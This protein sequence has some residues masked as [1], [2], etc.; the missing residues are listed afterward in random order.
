MRSIRVWVLATA[1]TV[2]AGGGGLVVAHLSSD[3][4]A[5]AWAA[6]DSPPA[7]A[8]VPPS[9]AA[10]P[11]SAGP[12]AAQLTAADAQLAADRA[13]SVKQ[14]NAALKS[15]KG[16]FSVAVHDR[17]AGLRYVHRG[18][19]KF[20]TASIVKVQVLTCMLLKAQDAGRGPTSAEMKLARPMI[21]LSDNNATTSL[22][23]RIGGRT[24]V[25]KC[26]K[27][28]GLTQTVVN[29][30]WGLTRTTAADQIRLLEELVD[31]RGPLNASSR[32]TAFTLMNTVDKAQ[33]WGVPVVAR[34]GEIF[35]VKNGWDTRTADGGLWAV[36]TIGRITSKNGKV[37]V[38][39]VVL[40]RRNK[41]YRSGIA[42]VERIAGLTRQHLRY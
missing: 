41:N 39:V 34:T 20:D 21:R 6:P 17:R 14:L 37:D 28:L 8:V 23:Q 27:R 38:S 15:V 4:P 32:K 40:S 35:T 9:P 18:S 29:S 22:Y 24:A 10:S 36:N 25:T 31:T 16:D 7:A 12:T 5:P 42:L 2:A 19:V 3:D 11:P 33:D 26:N 13:K 30:R 1:L